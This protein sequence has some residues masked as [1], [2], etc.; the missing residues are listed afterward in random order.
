MLQ[1]RDIELGEYINPDDI[2]AELEGSYDE[3]VAAAQ[4]IADQR[5]EVCIRERRSFSF[6]TVMSH[7]SKL[8]L[9]VRAKEAGFFVQLFFVGT[10]D[11]RTNV[12]RVALRVAQGGHSV[13]DDRIIARWVRTMSNLPDAIR[14]VDQTFVFDNS[15]A[16][17]VEAGGPRLVFRRSI[18][19]GR[20]LRRSEQIPPV[21]D[22]V[23]HYILRPLGITERLNVLTNLEPV[24]PAL[25]Q[26]PNTISGAAAESP[27]M[28]VPLQQQRGSESL[29]YDIEAEQGLLGAIL[30][31]NNVF[32]DVSEFLEPS[33]FFEDLH[34]RI[35]DVASSLIRAG[36][37]ATPNTLLEFLG[38]PDIAG[39]KLSQYLA[40]LA[41]EATTLASAERCGQTI[42]ELAVRRNLIMICEDVAAT[43]YLSAAERP[44]SALIQEAERRIGELGETLHRRAGLQ[45]FSDA[46][47]SAIDT[48]AANYVKGPPGIGLTTGLA[49]LDNKIGGLRPG[50]LAVI[51]GRHG[52]GKTSLAAQVGFN[53]AR[54]AR[55]SGL[56]DDSPAP[57]SGGA[58]GFFS[59][60][61]SSEQLATRIISARSG[62]PTQQISRGGVREDDFYRLTEAAREMQAI[63]FYI[64]DARNLSTDQL[65]SRA[66]RLMQTKGLDIVIIDDIK[67]LAEPERHNENLLRQKLCQILADLKSTAVELKVPVLA[68]LDL[69]DEFDES[70]DGRSIWAN[71]RR[72]A[73][74]DRDADLII[75]LYR[76]S[77]DLVEHKP[78]IGTV[79]YMQWVTEMEGEWGKAELLISVGRHGPAG[80]VFVHFDPSTGHFTDLSPD[81]AL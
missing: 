27:S 11:P 40:H 1:A 28:S 24:A 70:D 3:R 14:L 42:N 54:A 56:S 7:R 30:V 71:L 64:D 5:R 60:E 46:L 79:E 55:G 31:N 66:R 80:H 59:L 2:A 58:V 15:A 26:A 33:F 57:A 77:R 45:R 69:S 65:A 44:I 20:N 81:A 75:V 34:R 51:V 73:P 37:I 12:E 72:W 52:M 78:P 38:D 16:G 47:V 29:P 48:A 61:L 21:P 36:G 19:S 25:D 49:D 13:P 4:Q 22:W 41:A 39:I 6:E 74:I 43:A 62:V 17:L 9:L 76:R 53:L 8:D 18:I 63:P 23:R 67:R 68:T 50:E 35:Y 32:Y 10:D